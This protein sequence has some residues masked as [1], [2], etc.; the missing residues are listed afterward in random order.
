LSVFFV[1]IVIFKKE[2]N[3]HSVD[4]VSRYPRRVGFT[5]IELLVVIAIIAVLIALLLPAVQQAREAA[6]RTQCKNILK[7]IGLAHQ[8]YYDSSLC[9]AN[10]ANA[11]AH[12]TWA[13]G[14]MPFLDLTND[15]NQYQNYV[16]PVAS[17]WVQPPFYFSQVNVLSTTS[18]RFNVY[19]CPSDLQSTGWSGQDLT[20]SPS[21]TNPPMTFHNYSGN[22]G[23]TNTYS[24]SDYN[25]V[26]YLPGIFTMQSPQYGEGRKVTFASITDGTSSTILVGEVLQ[27]PPATDKTD[28]SKCDLR[29]SLWCGLSS[30]FTTY[31]PPNSSQPDV[32]YIDG[33]NFCINNPTLGLPCTTPTNDALGNSNAC[34]LGS[35][36][37]HAGGVHAAL[38]D[39][40]V[41]FV[42]NSID[43]NVWRALSSIQGAEVIGDF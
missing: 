39:G 16:I 5:L 11:D 43:I 37:R 34:T 26:K 23:T 35:R 30:M 25:N 18:R 17:E 32:P 40:S 19:T 4:Q 38:C 22:G 36:S 27:G 13:L 14:I 1:P 8:N 10:G 9:F 31:L 15:F 2:T 20:G 29:G 33:S 3:M 24:W 41:R 12:G 21:S 7:Q 42:S 6:R 28:T